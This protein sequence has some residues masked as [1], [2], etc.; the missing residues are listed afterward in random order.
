MFIKI[1]LPLILAVLIGGFFYIA[2]SDV[3][4]AQKEITK[5]IADARFFAK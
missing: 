1:F 4:V 5:T 3:P 2:L